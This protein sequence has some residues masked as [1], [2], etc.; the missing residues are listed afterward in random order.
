MGG[1][2]ALLRR[3]ENGRLGERIPGGK[4]GGQIEAVRCC[5]SGI[6]GFPAVEDLV[7]HAAEK[8]GCQNALPLS[9]AVLVLLGIEVDQPLHLRHEGEDVFLIE[10]P[11]QGFQ[12]FRSAGEAAAS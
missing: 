12:Q 10:V 8:V 3:P 9:V 5:Q 2:E 7:L 4:D 11:V 1:D 6:A